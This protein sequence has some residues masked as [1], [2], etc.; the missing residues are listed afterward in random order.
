MLAN[1]IVICLYFDVGDLGHHERIKSLTFG[2][3]DKDSW[4][5]G[6]RV[7]IDC[8]IIEGIEAG[9]SALL[10]VCILC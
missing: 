5:C 10:S 4:W 7:S 3:G 6:Q 8:A 9:A 1:I 2:Y